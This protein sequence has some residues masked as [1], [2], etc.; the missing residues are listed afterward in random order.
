[1]KSTDKFVLVLVASLFLLIA[2]CGGGGGSSSPA[3]DPEPPM[4]PDPEPTGPTPGQMAAEAERVA[5]AI[6][7]G[8]NNSATQL[9]G[10]GVV[11]GGDD[12]GLA[13]GDIKV[14][15]GKVEQIDPPINLQA[16]PPVTNEFTMSDTQADI[17]SEW[18]GST[19]TR[20]RTGDMATDMV[21]I[22]TDI[23]ENA[24][25]PYDEY[26]T[27]T[28]PDTAADGEAR[29]AWRGVSAATAEGVL[30]LTPAVGMAHSLFSADA[31]P[32]GENTFVVFEDDEDTASRDERMFEGMF[33]GISGTFACTGAAGDCRAENNAMGNLAKLEAPSGA[34]WTFTPARSVDI[35][36]ARVASVKKDLDYLDFG[37]WREATDGTTGLSYVVSPF[38]VG[39]DPVA[40]I[41]T[42]RGSASYAGPATGVYMQKRVNDDGSVSPLKSGQF[43]ASASLTAYFGQTAAGDPGVPSGCT[44]TGCNVI[45]PN[46]LSSINGMVSN[47]M[48]GE[49]NA[50]PSTW[51]VELMQ[52]SLAGLTAGMF[53]GKTTGE[54]TWNGQFFGLTANADGE[55]I[56]PGSVGG[57]FD[58][59]FTNGHVAGAFAATK[60]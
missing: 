27:P 5:K 45:S 7:G 34:T 8:S 13:A 50:L 47:F 30:T 29:I 6:G 15:G 41:P 18:T 52:A 60:E 21:V 23:K 49:G 55:A 24:S 43:T 10:S 22:Y 39:S 14:G 9:I 51:T 36:Q 19:H 3:P 40:T 16:D 53:D 4:T 46:L 32:S 48:D 33:H 17:S 44:G 38:V 54:G 58:G 20:E 42:V 57:T 25:L 59:H 26:Y 12:T 1:M 35:E 11:S 56:Q 37:Y 2:G 28:A 31:L